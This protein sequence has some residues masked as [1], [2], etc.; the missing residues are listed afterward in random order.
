MGKKLKVISLQELSFIQTH[1]RS[2][3]PKDGLA[4]MEKDLPS[5]AI[6]LKL[7]LL[8]P[9]MNQHLSQQTN[10]LLPSMW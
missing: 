7:S 4:S 6:A 1:L 2:V 8:D 3:V 9:M 10:V 5:E